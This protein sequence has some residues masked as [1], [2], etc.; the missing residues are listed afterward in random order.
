[1]GRILPLAVFLSGEGTTCDALADL[2]AGG[3]LSARIA[4]VLSDR[5]HAPG[6]ERARHRGLP[7][8]VRPLHGSDPQRWSEETDPLLHE[9]GAELVVL[10]GFLGIVPAEFVRRWRGRIINVHPS[11]LPLHGGAGMYGAHVHQAVLDGN[12][13]QSGATVH[14]VT[15]AIDAGPILLQESIPVLPEDTVTSLRDRLRPVET[16]LLA[17]TIRRFAE[18]EWPLPHPTPGPVPPAGKADRGPG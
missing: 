4:L 16:R 14:L 11:L 18:G 2:A 1:M 9:R 13:R 17:E 6:I 7:T 3:H 8:A 10:A 5:P 12:D 15:E